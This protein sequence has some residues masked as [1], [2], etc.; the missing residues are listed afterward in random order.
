[1]EADRA[2]NMSLAQPD[3]I[4]AEEFIHWPCVDQDI[5]GL[6]LVGENVINV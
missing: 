3:L 4:L 2:W 1:M 5:P 6:T